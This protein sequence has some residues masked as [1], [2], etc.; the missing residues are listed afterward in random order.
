M[1]NAELRPKGIPNPNSAMS[2]EESIVTKKRV[3]SDDITATPI[4]DL[5]LSATEKSLKPPRTKLAPSLLHLQ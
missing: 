3:L 4:V 2:G 5:V 1:K